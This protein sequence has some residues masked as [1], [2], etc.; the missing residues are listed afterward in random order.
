MPTWRQEEE[1]MANI[2]GLPKE[3]PHHK[4]K[5]GRPVAKALK[6][7]HQE[8]FSK[9][10]EVVWLARW[11]YFKA[12]QPN[13][14]QEGSY[15]LSPTSQQ[16]ATSMNL[17]GT[18]IHEVP[19]SWVVGRISELPTKLLSPDIHFFSVVAP[20]DLLK[21]M[22]LKGIHSPKTFQWQ[23]GLAFCLWCG[24]ECQNEGTIVN[25]LWIMHDH[26]GLSCAC[27]LEYFTTSADALCWHAQLCEPMA[28]S[29]NDD[30]RED[31]PPD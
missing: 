27:C 4:W 31:S 30:D 18:K 5:E 20:T 3:H 7:T 11:A 1:E 23:S 22:G 13:F 29:D 26:L 15:D 21:I 12:H 16:M 17:L 28:S 8:T 14:E 19:E 10:L 2:N 24:K 25:H 9:E 6:E